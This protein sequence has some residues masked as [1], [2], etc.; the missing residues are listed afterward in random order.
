MGLLYQVINVGPSGR[1]PFRVILL[2][3]KNLNNFWK[4]LICRRH[5]DHGK[6]HWKTVEK[7]FTGLLVCLATR[8]FCAVHWGELWRPQPWLILMTKKLRYFTE[9]IYY[10]KKHEHPRCMV[11]RYGPRINAI[12]VANARICRPICLVFVLVITFCMSYSYIYLWI[13]TSKLK[14]P[15]MK[16]NLIITLPGH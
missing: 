2:L 14:K 7:L 15:W 6:I 11:F 13:C 8:C 12:Y 1:I 10:F 16:I 9:Y 3:L 5:S 4:D